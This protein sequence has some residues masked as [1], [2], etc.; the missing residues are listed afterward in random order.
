VSVIINVNWLFALNLDADNLAVNDTEIGF[1]FL[2]PA[3]LSSSEKSAVK[4]VCVCDR[5]TF[6]LLCFAVLYTLL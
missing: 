3:H 4:Q 6:C 1:T 5:E 2:V